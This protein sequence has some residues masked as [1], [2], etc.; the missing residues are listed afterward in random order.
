[1][2]DVNPGDVRALVD[3]LVRVDTKVH[4][5]DNGSPARAPRQPGAS[6]PL[7]ILTRTFAIIIATLAS[8]VAIN[9]W[10]RPWIRALLNVLEVPMVG[11]RQMRRYIDSLFDWTMVKARA[12]ARCGPC[13]ALPRCCRTGLCGGGCAAWTRPL[14]AERRR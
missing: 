11:G 13:H 5:S 7:P 14:G 1:M 4:A 12:R 9:F 8:A 6:V 10:D 3:Q 2:A